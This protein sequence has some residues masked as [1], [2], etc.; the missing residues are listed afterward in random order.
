MLFVA[1]LDYSAEALNVKRRFL[2]VDAI[3][4][5]EGQ[6]DVVFWSVVLNACIVS[7]KIEVQSVGSCTGIDRIIKLIENHEVSALAA[8]DLDYLPIRSCKSTSPLVMYTVGYSIENT[9]VNASSLAEIAASLS[10]T[11]V[12]D[13]ADAENWLNRF[14]QSIHRLVTTD[15]LSQ[16]SSNPRSVM[17]DNCAKFMKD[18]R[19]SDVCDKKISEAI[20]N[21]ERTQFDGDQHFHDLRSS[22]DSSNLIVRGHFLFS[23]ALRYVNYYAQRHRKSASLS[24]EAFTTMLLSNWRLTF[25]K[26]HKDFDYYSKCM[27]LAVSS[28]RS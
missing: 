20:S 25:N 15:L 24:N 12:S 9:L 14:W 21:T 13:V 18:S 6:D 7:L 23:A 3:L 16:L 4:Y 10:R 17:G 26:T 2:G 1:S 19:S 8:R 5:V 11:T 22:P 27:K 28:L